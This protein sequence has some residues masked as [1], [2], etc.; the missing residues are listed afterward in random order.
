MQLCSIGDQQTS[1][2]FAVSGN[3]LSTARASAGQSGRVGEQEAIFFV[4]VE[5]ATVMFKIGAEVVPR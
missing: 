5:V 4:L 2:I 3:L 1:L